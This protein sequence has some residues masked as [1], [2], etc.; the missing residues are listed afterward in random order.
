MIPTNGVRANFKKTSSC[1]LCFHM[2]LVLGERERERERENKLQ[3]L[4][5][6]HHNNNTKIFVTKWKTLRTSQRKKPLRASQTLK[7][8]IMKKIQSTDKE[9]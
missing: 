4:I 8:T 7:I 1:S 9:T 2:L 5:I 6:E 3:H